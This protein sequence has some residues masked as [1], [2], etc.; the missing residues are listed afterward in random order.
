M[1]IAYINIV[2]GVQ[3][4]KRSL[5]GDICVWVC[6][7]VYMNM[8]VWE[9]RTLTSESKLFSW[10]KLCS[11]SLIASFEAE[12]VDLLFKLL[13]NDWWCISLESSLNCMQILVLWL[14]SHCEEMRVVSV[15]I[16]LEV[17]FLQLLISRSGESSSSIVW[18]KYV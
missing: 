13:S 3:W 15:L 6:L 9:E 8:C 2:Y 12:A 16:G 7:C 10:F 11:N 17:S 1:Q 4:F 5:C 14:W 18:W